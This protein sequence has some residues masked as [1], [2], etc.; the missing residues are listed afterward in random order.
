MFCKNFFI[1][2]GGILLELK[3]KLLAILLIFVFIASVGSAVAEDVSDASNELEIDNVDEAVSVDDDGTDD[4]LEEDE[5]DYEDDPDEVDGAEDEEESTTCAIS[6]DVLDKPVAGDTFRI[7]V[8]VTNTGDA[9]AE[10]VRGVVTFADIQG[11]I[12]K[13]FKLVDNGGA[14]VTEVNGAYAI[15]F[16]FLEAGDSKDV[17]LTFLATESGPKMIVGG[18]TGDN[19][20]I[21]DESFC[22]V[23]IDVAEPAAAPKVSAASET[24]PATGNPLA[25]LALALLAIVPIY[26]RR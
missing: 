22:Y 20:Q 17:I 4:E 25:L 11:K 13:G 1:K 16:G 19:V 5:G 2:F 6:I 23:I 10:N 14:T 24:L 7:K 8:T 3:N 15:D 26:R 21:T 18:V 9:D 12:D